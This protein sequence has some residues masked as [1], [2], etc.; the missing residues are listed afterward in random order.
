MVCP[1]EV[2]GC[3]HF[4]VD[5]MAAPLARDEEALVDQLLEGEH[6]RAARHAEFLGK[7]KRSLVAFETCATAHYWARAAS[8]GQN[9]GVLVDLAQEV[10]LAKAGAGP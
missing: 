9:E 7:Q 4:R 8:L 6:H 3:Q 5:E 2:L 1:A 10:A